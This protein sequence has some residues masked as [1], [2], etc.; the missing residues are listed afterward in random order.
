[1]QQEKDETLRCTLNSQRAIL[2]E[3]GMPTPQLVS[4][5]KNVFAQYKEEESNSTADVELTL[6]YTAASRLWYRCGMKLSCLGTILE[7]KPSPSL[8]LITFEDFLAV[9][10][11]I[12]E[13][14]E[15]LFKTAPLKDQTPDTICEVRAV[16]LKG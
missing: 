2:I 14:D 13:E 16:T 10:E 5:L 6:S 12:V 1:V 7:E 3:D 11:K 15:T 8:P 9:I 4:V